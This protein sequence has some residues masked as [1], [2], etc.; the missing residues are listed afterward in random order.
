MHQTARELATLNKVTVFRGGIWKPR[1][2]PNS[3]E[4]VGN[5][6]LKWFTEAAKENGFLS[7][8]EVANATHVEMA[9]RA[10]VD[11][12]WIGARTTVNPFSVQEI[13]D[14]VKGCDVPVWVKNPLNPDLQLWLGALERLSQAGITKLAAIHRGFA[15]NGQSQ[16]RNPPKW[17]LPIEL[18]RLI[19]NLE[20]ICDPSHISGNRELLLPIAQ[21]ALDLEMAGLMLETHCDPDNAWSD[22]K[23]Q[24]TP[25]QFGEL[26]SQL[27]V[28]SITG[29]T[30][31]SNAL[32]ELRKQIDL[33]DEDLLEKLSSRMRLVEQIARYKG[34]HN[35]T[36]LQMDRWRDVIS[37]WDNEASRFDLPHEFVSNLLQVIHKESIR[38]QTE[39][40]NR[41]KG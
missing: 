9:L 32:E 30:G 14:S 16:Y 4:G 27:I 31:N 25:M 13:A 20:I 38:K 2:R 22:A 17:D 23:Q 29:S 7:A 36:I 33:V 3:F 15:P 34:E 10:G 1:T 11:I 12:L 6:G 5:I 37:K 8:T 26:L 28:R 24:I 18:K 41:P 19:P 39:V 35:I 40:M 21:K